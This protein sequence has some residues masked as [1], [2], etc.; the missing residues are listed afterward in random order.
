MQTNMAALHK[1]PQAVGAIDVC[2]IRIKVPLKDAEDYIR[3]Y[4]HFIV[5]KGFFDDN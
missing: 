5:I 1:Y 4:Y 3:K 2:H